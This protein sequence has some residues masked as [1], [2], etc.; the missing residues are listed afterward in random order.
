MCDNERQ[1]QLLC[2]ERES[3][4]RFIADFLHQIEKEGE[5]TMLLGHPYWCDITDMNM[6]MSCCHEEHHVMSATYQRN[7]MNC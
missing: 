5:R 2:A 4:A 7:V 1:R 6:F 3:K